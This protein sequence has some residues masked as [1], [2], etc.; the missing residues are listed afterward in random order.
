[1]WFVEWFFSLFVG[2]KARL[3]KA[4]DDAKKYIAV[5]EYQQALAKHN[6]KY[7]GKKRFTKAPSH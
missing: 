6:R 2:K 3:L 1:M 4:Q 5:K 7:S